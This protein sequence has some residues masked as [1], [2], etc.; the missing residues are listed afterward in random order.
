MVSAQSSSGLAYQ[1]QLALEG[2][3]FHSPSGG[4]P[5]ATAAGG[6]VDI[7]EEGASQHGLRCGDGSQ[8]HEDAETGEK[9]AGSHSASSSSSTLTGILRSASIR[10][11]SPLLSPHSQKPNGLVVPE[12]Q[13]P[14]SLVTVNSIQLLVAERYE[15]R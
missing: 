1:R 6:V 2:A 10:Y 15:K 4:N 8:S 11:S 5:N 9:Q 3:S 14:T 7:G 13:S 12:Y